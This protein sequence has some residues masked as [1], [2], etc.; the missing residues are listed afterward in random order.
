MGFIGFMF[1]YDD[2]LDYYDYR[3]CMCALYYCLQF[4]QF[5]TFF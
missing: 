4:I 3:F 5:L 1:Y 2:F